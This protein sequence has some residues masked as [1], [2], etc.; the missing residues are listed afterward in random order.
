L[1]INFWDF[2]A[3]LKR[4]INYHE[5]AHEAKIS[6]LRL[7]EKSMSIGEIPEDEIIRKI[8]SVLKYDEKELL[9]RAY[10]SK[11]PEKLDQLQL[12]AATYP[13]L[14]HELLKSCTDEKFLSDIFSLY[15]FGELERSIYF[16][17]FYLT[18][19]I[20]ERFFQADRAAKYVSM[21]HPELDIN[22]ER[23]AIAFF[24]SSPPNTEYFSW[25]LKC[26]DNYYSGNFSFP[27]FQ[28]FPNPKHYSSEEQFTKAVTAYN[29]E[30]KKKHILHSIYLSCTIGIPSIK[31]WYYFPDLKSA[32]IID[33]NNNDFVLYLP[34]QNL[35]L[36]DDYESEE[37]KEPSISNTII[38]SPEQKP[39]RIN[40]VCEIHSYNELSSF[41]QN[42]SSYGGINITNDMNAI[43]INCNDLAPIVYKGQILIYSAMKSLHSGDYVLIHLKNGKAAIRKYQKHN[44]TIVFESILPVE[45]DI[46]NES[47]EVKK[48][49]KILGVWFDD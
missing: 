14:R 2:I 23:K 29:I 24:S 15:S 38:Q 40:I 32:K 41:F 11:E 31:L 37:I 4:D 47:I 1:Q 48:C 17:F 44:N 25:W 33:N 35:P 6:D 26:L 10:Y 3:F 39:S 20:G 42:Q 22:K 28:D 16:V 46:T 5:L 19:F 27:T 36:L 7:L 49:Y 21:R 45:K 8:A 18:V 12:P 34:N 13:Y 9:L 30:L 43:K